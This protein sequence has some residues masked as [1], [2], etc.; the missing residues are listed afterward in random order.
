MIAVVPQ[1]DA[2]GLDSGLFMLSDPDNP[3]YYTNLSLRMKGCNTLIV[4]Q[5]PDRD[6]ESYD[7]EGCID[8]EFVELGELYCDNP[9]EDEIAASCLYGYLQAH[10]KAVAEI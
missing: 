8:S 2:N 10:E 9:Y 3:N 1:Y 4:G 7:D 5:F 6:N